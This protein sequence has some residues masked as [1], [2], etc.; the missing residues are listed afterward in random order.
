MGVGVGA[1][2]QSSYICLFTLY[3]SV[4]L[5]HNPLISENDPLRDI[6]VKQ[7][8]KMARILYGNAVLEQHS[9]NIIAFILLTYDPGQ[10]RSLRRLIY[11][12]PVTYVSFS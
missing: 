7:P 6:S 12:F 5:Y 9:I 8:R 2:G 1:G 3:L 4:V 11:N 10:D